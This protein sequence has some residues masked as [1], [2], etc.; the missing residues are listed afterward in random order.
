MHIPIVDTRKLSRSRKIYL[1]VVAGFL[2]CWGLNVVLAL[3]LPS[4]F[5]FIS[6]AILCCTYSLLGENYTVTATFLPEQHTLR[7]LHH[8]GILETWSLMELRQI[9]L[10]LDGFEN[11]R[12]NTLRSFR[13]IAGINNYIEFDANGRH[14]HYNLLLRRVDIPA[15]RTLVLAWFQAG[16]DLRLD[17]ATQP[18][19]G[20]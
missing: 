1:A 2:L 5:F 10:W 18:E 12:R 16:A 11:D 13:Y 8:N 9:H 14:H 3:H 19:N 15:L 6:F 17:D 20:W 7:V 4:L